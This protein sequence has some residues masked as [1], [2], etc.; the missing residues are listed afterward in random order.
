MGA[1][2]CEGA[3]YAL[4]AQGAFGQTGLMSEPLLLGGFLAQAAYQP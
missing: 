2:A 1:S 4:A 3:M